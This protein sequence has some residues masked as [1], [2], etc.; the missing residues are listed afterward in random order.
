M[1]PFG[2]VLY[3][4]QELD[5]TNSEALRLLRN[6]QIRENTIITATHQTAGRG[7]NG[8]EWV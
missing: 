6:Q 4:Y 8:K 3:K 2:Y 5:S 1:L 7:R